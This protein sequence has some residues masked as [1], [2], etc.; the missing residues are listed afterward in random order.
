MNEYDSNRILD[1][2]KNINYKPTKKIN[3]ADCYV[4]NTCHIREKATEKVY[5]DIGRVKKE[6]RNRKKPILIITGCVAQAEGDEMLKQEKYIDAVIGPQ[7]Y[8]EIPEIIK[9]AETSK[10]RF[11]STE[12]DVIEKFDKLN[13]FKNSNSKISSFITI[14]EGCDKFCNF[15][16][17]PYTRGPEYSRSIKEIITEVKQLIENGVKEITLLGQNVNAYKHE[18]NKLSDLIY[19]LN[20]IKGIE[21]IKFTTS[22]P[23]DMTD[24]LIEVYK[25]CNKLMPLLH[26]PVQSGSNK[27]LKLMNR[28]HS[29]EEYLSI[30]ERLQNKKPNIK[31][32]SDFIIGYPNETEQDFADTIN[33]LKRVKFINSYSFIFSARP[34][35]PSNRLS[36]ID[37]EVAKKRL[38]V[39]QELSDEIKKNY[40]KNLLNTETNVLFENKLEQKDRYFGRDEFSNS[41]IVDSQVNLTG[42]IINTKINS[43]NGNT[44]FGEIVKEK[45]FAA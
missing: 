21:R 8:H 25:N 45:E 16:V 2:V 40:R 17:V 27:I 37:R 35:T 31:F 20:N 15:C 44:L 6:F 7:S 39:F 10:K 5:H 34:G 22:H 12:F 11:N 26:L 43:F 33:L 9:K 4:L 30:I 28:K 13:L 3:Y 1:L 32:S 14:Q 38:K 24:D 29:V 23:K 18:K 36:P 41:I 42:R 19:T